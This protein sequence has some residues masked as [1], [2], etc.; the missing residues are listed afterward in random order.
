MKEKEKRSFSLLDVIIVLFLLLFVTLGVFLYLE[1][2]ENTADPGKEIADLAVKLE[3]NSM[4]DFLRAGSVLYDENY[5]EIGKVVLIRE[6]RINRARDTAALALRCEMEAG[7]AVPGTE[8]RIQ[9][10]DLIFTAD[11]RSAWRAEDVAW[12]GETNE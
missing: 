1:S 11:V 4:A 5:R 2:R 9:T 10:K 7:K 8:I 3:A 12:Q 6:K